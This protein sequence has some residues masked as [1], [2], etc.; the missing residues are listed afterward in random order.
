MIRV[1]RGVMRCCLGSLG[2]AA[3]MFLRFFPNSLWNRVV[4]KVV[5]ESGGRS[6]EGVDEKSMAWCS[7]V[8]LGVIGTGCSDDCEIF[9]WTRYGSESWKKWSGREWGEAWKRVR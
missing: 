2:Q 4:E 6:V 7:E 8:L 5:R 3:L 9:F 1:W